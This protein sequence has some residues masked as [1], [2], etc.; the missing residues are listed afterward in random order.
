M[1]SNKKV[2]EHTAV[3]DMLKKI[4]EEID[5]TKELSNDIE[6]F[7]GK[8]PTNKEIQRPKKK[9]NVTKS[10]HGSKKQP[11]KII[12]NNEKKEKVVIQKQSNAPKKNVQSAAPKKKMKPKKAP[13]VPQKK[14]QN[15]KKPN[16]DSIS[17]IKSKKSVSTP[18]KPIKKSKQL[19]S[20][21]VTKSDLSAKKQI[22]KKPIQK[23]KASTVDPPPPK[24]KKRKDTTLKES[25]D[26]IDIQFDE[27]P[28]VKKKK[29]FTKEDDEFD[30][31]P[32]SEKFRRYILMI[33]VTGGDP[34][35]EST[36]D[37]D[38]HLMEYMARQRENLG[39]A[40]GSYLQ[41]CD[42]PNKIL[43]TFL[44]SLGS[45][46]SNFKAKPAQSRVECFFGRTQIR[47]NDAFNVEITSTYEE[48]GE[49]KV[50]KIVRPMH[51]KWVR[52]IHN[53][54]MIA[55]QEKTILG[56]IENR[57]AEKGHLSVHERGAAIYRDEDFCENVLQKYKAAYNA[58][59]DYIPEEI[60]TIDL[61]W[62]E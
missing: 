29:I 49:T 30:N 50:L 27:K 17:K 26:I 14:K 13:E 61:E 53:W 34:E 28:K 22:K 9:A 5:T 47:K 43:H 4:E 59:V 24:N 56:Q 25:D 23:K 31:L 37:Q 44:A 21:K 6:G 33:T 12:S 55:T 19:K 35:W 42:G 52:L 3:K 45:T 51:S 36:D 40:F 20:S 18:V 54:C 41:G 39:Y 46:I 16:K 7:I 11:K 62:F 60:E 48:D 2:S 15:I 57:L 10:A 8:V 38:Q 1:E 32:L 58:L